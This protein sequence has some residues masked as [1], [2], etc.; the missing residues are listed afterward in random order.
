MIP[1]ITHSLDGV[2]NVVTDES[3][4]CGN[5]V[6]MKLEYNPRPHQKICEALVRLASASAWSFEER[7]TAAES[8]GEHAE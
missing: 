4:R 8:E 3:T 5:L 2:C 7:I 1:P 6:L